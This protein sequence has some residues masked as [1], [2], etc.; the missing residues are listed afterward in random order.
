VA[1]REPLSAL[2]KRLMGDHYRRAAEAK[3]E[4]RPVVYVTAMFP[5]EIAKTFEPKVAVVYPE[6]HAVSLIVSGLAEGMSQLGIHGASLDPMGCSYELANTGY[7]LAMR[8]SGGQGLPEGLDAVPRLPEPDI[9]LA[10]NNQCDI[11]AE[12]FQNLSALCGNKPFRVINVGNRY[13]GLVD[14]VRVGYVRE[15]I[16]DVIRMLEGETGTGLDRDRLL[17]TA[18]LSN[19]AVALWREYLDAGKLR[20]SPMTAF[21][22]FFHMALI[23]SERGTPQAVDYYERLV[24]ETR[25]RVEAGTPAVQPERHRVLWDN[26]ATWFNFGQLRRS[27]GSQGVAV[28][29]S[30]YLDVWRKELDTSSYDALLTSM[31]EA[32]CS[33][34]TNLTIRERIELWKGMVRDYGA[35]GILFHNNKSC[36]TFSRLQGQIAEALKEE[37][38]EEFKAIIFDGDMGLE[39]RFQKHRFFTAVETFFS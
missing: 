1:D 28:V 14:A 25:D 35:E 8:R 27:L 23:V 34:Y 30:T 21:D 5:V 12:W 9:L 7:L 10:C 4:G 38:G 22:G 39:E 3:E 19:Q 15:Q 16:E 20:P 31:A 2:Q 29:G 11:V 37:F 33:M 24:Q 26:L 32:Y 13:D 36:H 17:E 18:E 6:N